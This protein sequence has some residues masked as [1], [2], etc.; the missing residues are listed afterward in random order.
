[1]IEGT[2]T[3]KRFIDKA[4]ASLFQKSD[5]VEMADNDEDQP[6]TVEAESKGSERNRQIELE[7]A[8]RLGFK[9]GI[10]SRQ[11]APAEWIGECRTCSERDTTLTS[12]Q[13]PRLCHAQGPGIR[14]RSRVQ[15]LAR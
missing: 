4:L 6:K 14:D 11:N 7:D 13:T 15:H 10:G 1:M 9:A 2:L 8:V 3:L 12:S 5:D